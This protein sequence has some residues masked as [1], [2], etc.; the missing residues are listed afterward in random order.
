MES[1]AK[2]FGHPIHQMLIP[3][4]LGLLGTAVI[5]DI[6][7]LIWGN[8]TMVTVSYWMIVAGIIGALA[9]APFG[10]IDWLAIP[11]D[12]R[13]NRVGMLHGIGN[14]IVLALFAI[15]W[16]LRYSEQGPTPYVPTATA[17]VLSFAG[18]ALA[19][20]TGWLGGELVDRLSVG[21]DNG[22]NLDAPSS[23]TGPVTKAGSKGP[24]LRR[25]A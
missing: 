8:A 20:I 3:F 17:L 4:P 1:R 5:F 14:V 10:L 9:A 25:A 19:G 12:T 7:Y 24:D 2:I 18:F 15:S 6:I 13:A 22:A 21:V 16:Y 11:S 23:L